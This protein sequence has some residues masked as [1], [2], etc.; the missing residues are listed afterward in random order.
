MTLNQKLW[1]LL[2]LLGLLATDA[3]PE[4]RLHTV[5]VHY[6]NGAIEDARRFLDDA[7]KQDNSHCL[8]VW[9]VCGRKAG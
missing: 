5:D 2:G 7:L 1:L 3:T 4:A 8:H 6:K 9:R